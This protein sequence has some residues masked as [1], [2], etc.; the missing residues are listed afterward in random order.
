MLNAICLAL[1]VSST[2]PYN[3][4]GKLIDLMPEGATWG[5]PSGGQP[6]QIVITDDGSKVGPTEFKLKG[7]KW[8]SEAPLTIQNLKFSSG[9]LTGTVKFKNSSGHALDG[10]RFD[11]VSAS[12]LYKGTNG[13]V[14]TRAQTVMEESP[15]LFGDMPKEVESSEVDFKAAG[16]AWKPETSQITVTAKLSGLTFQKVLFPDHCGSYLDFDLKGR[17]LLGSRQ[18]PAIYRTDV[19]A[20][21][22]ESITS[23]PET[24]PVIAVNPLDGTICAHWMNGHNFTLYSPGGDEKGTIEQNGDVPGMIG[25]PQMG[26]YD[27]KGNLYL[28]FENTVAQ[29]VGGKPSFVLKGAGQYEFTGEVFFDVAKDGTLFVASESNVF[30]FEPGGKTP[31]KILQ[32]PDLKLGRIHGVQAIRLD[33]SGYL[34]IADATDGDFPGRVCVFD[35]NGKFVWTFGRGGAAKPDEGWLDGQVSGA[36]TSFAVAPDGH[37]YVANYEQERSVLAFTEF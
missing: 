27:A 4:T 18:Q 25:W 22:L 31:K 7:P 14:Q 37:V 10:V 16:L 30:R 11:I 36:I 15:I 29:I 19:D 21:T 20:G 6:I 8:D 1:A 24:S 23:T 34:W 2:A 5:M 3:Y 28:Q 17:L 32:G 12:E 9:V 33:P 26:H 13:A 35:S